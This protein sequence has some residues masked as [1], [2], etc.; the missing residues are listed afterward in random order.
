MRKKKSNTELIRERIKY[1]PWYKY[2][3]VLF[4]AVFF[5]FMVGIT[6]LIYDESQKLTEASVNKPKPNSGKTS[7]STDAAEG[8]EGDPDGNQAAEEYVYTH[9]LSRE[10]VDE[11]IKKFVSEHEGISESDYS[12]DLKNLMM[13]HHETEEFVLNY[14]LNV[15]IKSLPKTEEELS[16]ENTE[17]YS[18]EDTGESVTEDPQT[19]TE[20]DDSK[21][22]GSENA[23]T[24]DVSI[25]LS[26]IDYTSSVPEL[27][28]WDSRWAYK[29]YGSD[30]LGLTGCGPTSL[31]MVAMYLLQDESKTPSWIAD[32]SIREG[33]AVAGHGSSWEL[34]SEGAEKLGLI[35]EEIGLDE[36]SIA[37]ALR[38]GKPI[39]C[40]MGPGY[41]TEGGHYIVLVDYKGGKDH[42][43]ITEGGDIIVHDSNCVQNSARIWKFTELERQVENLWAFSVPEKIEY[44]FRNQKLLD[45]H[46][47]K[48]G[49]D[50]GFKSAAEYEKAA[51]DVINNPECLHKNEKED[52]DDVYY[53]EETNDFVILSTDGYIRTYFRPDGGKK[54]YDKQ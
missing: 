28:Q 6:V 11:A 19:T 32:F 42:D 14:P 25:N 26:N 34:M 49:K 17:E 39:I 27:Y 50:M 21:G 51:S 48:H 29:V 52:G 33:Y 1:Q 35:V 15:D 2:R 31:S 40:I 53:L 43:C 38:A 23:D 18:E 41:F 4:L 44:K 10:Q 12:D 24:K 36:T 37:E 8:S 30:V 54:Y 3:M 20:V 13:N 47:Q 45:Q 22:T 16:T 7:S 9:E 5:I 46:Y